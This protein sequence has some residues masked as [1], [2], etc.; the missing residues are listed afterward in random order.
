MGLIRCSQAE[1][2]GISGERSWQPS[3]VSQEQLCPGCAGESKGGEKGYGGGGR[4]GLGRYFCE[5]GGRGPYAKL[6]TVKS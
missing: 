1:E 4:G 6:L 2:A 3:V 5:F